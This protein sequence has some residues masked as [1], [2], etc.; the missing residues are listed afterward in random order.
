MTILY[1]KRVHEGEGGEISK[2]MTTW[3][4]DDPYIQRTLFFSLRSI[5]LFH[6]VYPHTGPHLW[7]GQVFGHYSGHPWVG[8]SMSIFLSVCRV[9]SKSLLNFASGRK[10]KLMIPLGLISS[11]LDERGYFSRS[12]LVLCFQNWKWIHTLKVMS[13]SF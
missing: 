2:K 9:S 11:V 5:H 8:T 3:F 1:C 12:T 6:L 4:I 7:Q 10:A 13:S